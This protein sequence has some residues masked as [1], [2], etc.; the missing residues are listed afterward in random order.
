VV[1]VEEDWNN[2]A[3]GVVLV[4][5]DKDD[6]VGGAFG[7][8]VNADEDDPLERDCSNSAPINKRCIPS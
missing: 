5:A 7:V 3:P 6:A 1:C 2:P 8:L 4:V